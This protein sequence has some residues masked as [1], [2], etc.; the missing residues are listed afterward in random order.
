MH[1]LDMAQADTTPASYALDGLLSRIE[2][3]VKAL[4]VG[5]KDDGV[6]RLHNS[7]LDNEDVDASN[8]AIP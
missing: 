3:M 5:L 1:A 6:R 2:G 8:I 7:Q 4:S